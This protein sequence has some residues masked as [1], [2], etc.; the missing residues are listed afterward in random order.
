[1][2][3]AVFN[4]EETKTKYI[5][6]YRNKNPQKLN[7]DEFLEEL[8]YLCFLE[9]HRKTSEPIRQKLIEG[10]IKKLGNDYQ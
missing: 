2:D 4:I 6:K 10:L 3:K 9:E 5:L 8:N 7:A 1:M